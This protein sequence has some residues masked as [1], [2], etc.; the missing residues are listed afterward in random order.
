MTVVSP[1]TDPNSTTVQVWVQ[2]DNP[3]EQLKPGTSVHVAI[4]DGDL[5]GGAGGAD[6]GDPSRA[7]RAARGAW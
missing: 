7:K 1:A 4:D 6:R 2:A 5:Q 3:G